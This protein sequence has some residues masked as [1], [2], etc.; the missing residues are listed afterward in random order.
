MKKPNNKGFT[1]I[2]LIVSF[3]ILGVVSA[4][5]VALVS[6]SMEY[7]R[8]VTQT[9]TLQYESQIV[10]TQIRERS[11]NCNGA[12]RFCDKTNTLYILNVEARSDG[13]EDLNVSIFRYNAAANRLEYV[14]GSFGTMGLSDDKVDYTQ[15]SPVSE[16]VNHFEV[17]VNRNSIIV[18]IGFFNQNNDYTG[19]Q[20][21]A[22][23]NDPTKDHKEILAKIVEG[24]DIDGG[25]DDEI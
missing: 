24:I 18:E 11:I 12:V 9:A 22:L 21:I 15:L 8:K 13:D 2:E 5:L 25:G 17:T 7:Y 14:D 6:Q 4:S 19:R 1:L 23:R 10:M 3:A 20:T 16:N